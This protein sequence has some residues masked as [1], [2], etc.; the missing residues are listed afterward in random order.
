VSK[1][2]FKGN[3]VVIS[4][5]VLPLFAIS[6][7]SLP[8]SA[9]AAPVPQLGLVQNPLD[10]NLDI[11]V[12][13]QDHVQFVRKSNG[14]STKLIMDAKDT[15]RI[16][17]ISE[18]SQG[19][20]LTLK[21]VYDD[22]LYTV[23]L[24]LSQVPAGQDP[25]YTQYY[26]YALG[27]NDSLELILEEGWMKESILSPSRIYDYFAGQVRIRSFDRVGKLLKI[28]SS[29]G[30]KRILVYSREG[31]LLTIQDVGPQGRISFFDQIA[32]DARTWELPFSLFS[33][34]SLYTLPN[35]DKEKRSQN[36]AAQSSD[37]LTALSQ[38]GDSI[39]Q[40]PTDRFLLWL[41][42]AHPLRAGPAGGL[43]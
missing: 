43:L 14:V 27:P 25:Q 23:T 28:E 17:L 20:T 33:H 22:A 15:D 24:L 36:T 5:I 41:E 13:R 7:L 40:N 8:V 4:L 34:E 19:K 31:K 6:F 9:Q 21:Y 2:R 1:F 30:A 12:D 38:Q 39:L 10:R 42:V 3:K 29:T 18:T 11:P 16:Y 32:A 37:I 26:R 35:R